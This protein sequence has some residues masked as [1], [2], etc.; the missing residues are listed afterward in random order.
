[1]LGAVLAVS[2]QGPR[3]RVTGPVVGGDPTVADGPRVITSTQAAIHGR[4]T[5]VTGSIAVP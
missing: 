1:M 3:H 4:G 5:V 2:A